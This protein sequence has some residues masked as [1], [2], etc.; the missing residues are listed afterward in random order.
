MQVRLGATHDP[1][2]SEVSRSTDRRNHRAARHA[3]QSQ[4]LVPVLGQPDHNR[5]AQSL[6]NI[7]T[8]VF[9]SELIVNKNYVDI[10][11]KD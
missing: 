9:F 11:T 3:V 4:D 10:R 7:S 5:V 2:A 8:E 6:K 1:K